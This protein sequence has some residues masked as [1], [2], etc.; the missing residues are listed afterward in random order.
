MNRE[1]LETYVW[2]RWRLSANQVRRSGFLGAIL[3]AIMAAARVMGGIVAFIAGLL[4]GLLTL[5]HAQPWALLAVWDGV[6][7]AFLFFWL[8]G[9]MVEL[10]RTELLSL[11]NFMHLPVSP[12]GAF[13]INFVGSSMGLSLIL[14]FPAMLGLG[15]GITLAR[16]PGMIL[17]LPLVTAFFLM[18]TAV[19][20]LFRGWLAGMMTNPRRRRT[21]I[22]VLTL[23]FVLAFQ[24][25]YFLARLNPDAGAGRRAMRDASGRIASLEEEHA[26]GRI[27]LQEY[28]ERLA[29]E[30]S[31]WEAARDRQK[32]RDR[33]MLRS[34][35]RTVPPGWL[36]YGAAEAGAGRVFPALAGFAGM[37]LIGIASLWFSYRNAIRL[38]TGGFRRGRS[39]AKGAERG[40]AKPPVTGGAGDRGRAGL[41]EMGIPWIPEQAAAVSLAGFRALMRAPEMKMMLLT[42]VIM[43]VV[44][45]GV[46]AGGKGEAAVFVR[47]L[48]A[49][50]LA[51]GVLV[52]GFTGFVGNQFALDRG[53][54]R[55][56]VLGCAPRRDI[57]LGKNLSMLPIAVPLMACMAGLSQWMQPMRPDH[58]AAVLVQTI[59]MYL[60]FCLAGNLLSILSPVALKA[61][62]SQPAPHQGMRVLL[63]AVFMLVVPLLLGLTLAPLG[64]A[65]LLSLVQGV[66]WFPAFLVL[67]MLQAAGVLWLYRA[68][69]PWQGSLLERHEK[70]ILEVVCSKVE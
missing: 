22:A 12:A 20:Y 55:A 65:T 49:L 45:G 7:A 33:E 26:E 11:D 64:I 3:V 1:H 47:P 51:A 13:L 59:P 62:S 14:F 10:Q 40:E 67:G 37:S 32:D 21:I 23:L 69:I 31:A 17:T 30:R 35:S 68:A 70:K 25:P 42:P 43:L 6:A 29:A 18:I 44:F 5:R 36:A 19:T 9:L 16:G 46:A 24:I 57:V 39:R 2:V 27:G 54:F 41:L 61:G 8:V 60:L 34:I 52:F 50:G 66:A 28:E 48:I 56:Y 63:Q 38:Y 58:L 15:T 53:G 4:A